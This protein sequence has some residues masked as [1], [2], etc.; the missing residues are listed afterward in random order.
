MKTN[1]YSILLT[2]LVYLFSTHSIFAQDANAILMQVKTRLQKVKDYTA[3]GNLTTDVKFIKIPNSKV[4]VY[5]KAP[6]QFKILKED[7]ISI[8]PKGGASVSL[9]SLLSGKEFVAI[10]GGYTVLEKQRL[11]V[12]K[13]L[14]SI[15]NSDVVLIT[16]F[17]DE[18][19]ALV[20]KSVTTT[21]DNGTYE[22]ILKYGKYRNWGLPDNVLFIFSTTAFKLPKALTMEYE[23][24]KKADAQKTPDDGKGKISI[25]YSRYSINSGLTADVFK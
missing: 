4:K 7:G 21:K 9:N 5:F 13:L 22:A 24:D 20:H 14:P 6:D 10:P 2:G 8:L 16:L 3:E 25:S 11:A 12:I 23:G 17:V 1:Y 15:E 18:D 19:Q